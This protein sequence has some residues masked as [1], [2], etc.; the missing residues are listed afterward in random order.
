MESLKMNNGLKIPQK[1][2][3]TW[4]LHGKENIEKCFKEAIRAGYRHFD[5][6]HTYENEKEI[7][8]VLKEMFASGFV[9]REDLFITSKIWN[10]W[11]DKVDDAIRTTL[12]DLQLDY[13]DL[14]LIHWPVHAKPDENM[15][16]I[17]ENGLVVQNKFDLEI[18]WPK[19]EALV[20]K[21]L[22]KSIGVSNFGVKSIQKTLNIA[23]IKP[24]CNQIE[25]H[26]FLPQNEVVKMCNDNGIVVSSYS[27][28]RSLPE[29][30][31]NGFGKDLI[32][33][34]EDLNIPVSRLILSYIIQRGV[35]AIT[36]SGTVERIS[37]NFQTLPLSE[38]TM[39]RIAKITDKK[40]YVDPKSFGEARF[41]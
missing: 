1:A 39:D 22:V 18:L 37:E 8:E 17:F 23:M 11:H 12:D 7:G 6:A 38:D 16:S 28:L 29:I 31:P 41:D 4:N 27:S 34:S 20:E 3:G 33:I 40:R 21:N 15:Q 24:V 32:S 35:I 2:F 25:L 10:T 30:K 13:L 14:Y 36:K 9:K 19:M 26:P 5:F